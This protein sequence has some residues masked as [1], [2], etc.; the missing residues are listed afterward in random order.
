MFCGPFLGACIHET[1]QRSIT[2]EN[3]EAFG[4]YK[5]NQEEFT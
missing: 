4:S 1:K 5:R 2:I 3:T